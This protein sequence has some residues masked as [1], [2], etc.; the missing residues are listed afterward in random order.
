MMELINKMLG[1]SWKTSLMGYLT[2]L[3]TAGYQ[4]FVEQGLPSN[5]QEWFSFVGKLTIALGLLNA[6][7]SNVTNAPKPAPPAT[8]PAAVQA[9][10]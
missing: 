10:T 6:K 7:D 3:G 4:V 5:S 8:V 2:L 9:E 1:P